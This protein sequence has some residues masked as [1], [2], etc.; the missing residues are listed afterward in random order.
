MLR[1]EFQDNANTLTMRI[2]G[3]F[4]GQYAEE[5]KSLFT[6]S[7]LLPPRLVVDVSEVTFIDVTGEK[8][9]SWLGRMGAE[10][11]AQNSYSRDVCERLD[12][13]LTETGDIRHPE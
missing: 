3:R 11:V 8:V 10:F 1:V 2:E 9:L 6:G 12:L 13:P 5:A 4:V 7:K